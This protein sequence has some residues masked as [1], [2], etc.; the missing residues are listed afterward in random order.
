MVNSRTESVRTTKTLHLL[1]LSQRLNTARLDGGYYLPLAQKEARQESACFSTVQTGL[2]L[3]ALGYQWLFC[4]C[5][6][7]CFYIRSMGDGD[8]AR[9]KC[10]TAT[11]AS[12]FIKVLVTLAKNEARGAITLT[13][14]LVLGTLASL[15]RYRRLKRFT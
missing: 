6:W 10:L 5:F 15:R 13:S 3:S 9:Y 8:R 1:S 11:I 7:R 12:Q 14:P 2:Q 4:Q